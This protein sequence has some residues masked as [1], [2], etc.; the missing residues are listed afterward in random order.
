MSFKRFEDDP[1]YA[2]DLYR[3]TKPFEHAQRHNK[4]IH[5]ACRIGD[6]F[7]VPAKGRGTIT[8]VFEFRLERENETF[9]T[10]KLDSGEHCCF[11]VHDITRRKS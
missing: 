7:H 8:N 3:D 1:D 4:V 10:V 11:Q 6:V 5:A 2:Y 9:I